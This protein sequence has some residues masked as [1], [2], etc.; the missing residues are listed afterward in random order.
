MPQAPIIPASDRLKKYLEDLYTGTVPNKFEQV[1]SQY[2]NPVS[3]LDT[4]YKLLDIPAI[5]KRRGF[6]SVTMDNKK[7]PLRTAEDLFNLPKANYWD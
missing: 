4:G 5:L 1:A 7:I 2:L 6:T 3:K